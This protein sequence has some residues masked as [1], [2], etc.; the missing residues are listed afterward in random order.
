M[1]HLLS[2]I[3]VVELGGGVAASYCGKLFADLGADVIKVESPRGDD[4]RRCGS[5][6]ISGQEQRGG[7][8][9]HLNTN[10]RS[11]VLDSELES[12]RVRLQRLVHRADLVIESRPDQPLSSW[13]TDWETLTEDSPEV[14]VVCISGFGVDGPY[15]GYA[16]DDIVVQAVAGALLL[17][18]DP[19][20]APLRLP[21]HTALY[22]V[23][24]VAGL[25]GLAA[26]LLKDR[27]ARGSFV[28]CSA[29][30]GAGELTGAS[31][32]DARLPVSRAPADFARARGCGWRHPDPLGRFPLRRWLCG[33]D[34]D[35]A[36]T[37]RD[38]GRAG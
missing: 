2:G 1:Q 29:V 22:F 21:G 4:L 18:N 37:Q 24:H 11:S 7:A 9:L 28:D 16:W 6:E 25:G 5:A 20:Q 31:G 34:V 23:G 33:N 13:G 36:T 26:V 27:T 10:K 38:A 3:K 8:F 35:S 30:R 15:S 17:Q 32:A 19:Q 12:D 14:S